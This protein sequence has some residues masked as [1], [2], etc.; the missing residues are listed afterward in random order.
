MPWHAVRL[1]STS[2]PSRLS[3]TF[4]PGTVV[5]GLGEG[6]GDGEPLVLGPSTEPSLTAPLCSAAISHG[7]PQVTVRW[8]TLKGRRS[9]LSKS[10]PAVLVVVVQT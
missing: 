5:E 10:R 9:A 2:S 8:P 1:D 6:H 4:I 3:T 7:R